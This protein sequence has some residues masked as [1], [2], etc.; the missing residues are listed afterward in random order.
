[1]SKL[2]DAV[3]PT[4]RQELLKRHRIAT[5]LRLR[6]EQVVRI[7][8]HP[9][10]QKLELSQE[11]CSLFALVQIR[12]DEIRSELES[13]E[14]LLSPG[15]NR[16]WLEFAAGAG[17]FLSQYGEMINGIN[18]WGYSDFWRCCK[19]HWNPLRSASVDFYGFILKARMSLENLPIEDAKIAVRKESL[20]LE[21]SRMNEQ[22]SLLNKISARLK[23]ESDKA[24]QALLESLD[25]LCGD[26]RGEADP[27]DETEWE[28]ALESLTTGQAKI[29]KSLK[30]NR[31]L[32]DDA[33]ANHVNSEEGNPRDAV[34]KQINNINT[35]WKTGRHPFQINRNGR[36]PVRNTLAE[37]NPDQSRTK[38]SV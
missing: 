18:R 38:E 6:I 3:E 32:T 11:E 2:H 27:V 12:L 16:Q 8:G 20:S 29:A 23:T 4:W 30:S 5:E 26:G 31:L 10:K 7:I 22:E 19:K 9:C 36:D 21:V 17:K 25:E 24:N 35:C 15:D 1:M 34:R 33:L 28:L 13:D 14:Q 37:R